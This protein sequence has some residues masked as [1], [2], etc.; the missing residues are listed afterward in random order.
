MIE[1]FQIFWILASMQYPKDSNINLFDHTQFDIHVDQSDSLHYSI[2]PI[3]LVID[4]MVQERIEL[5][6]E[7]QVL[8]ELARQDSI[9]QWNDEVEYYPDFGSEDN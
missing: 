7:M 2:L 5:E 1:Y 4:Q 6:I 8:D 3:G 9:K